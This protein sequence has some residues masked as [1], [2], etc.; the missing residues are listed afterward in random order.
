M[1]KILIIILFL[2]QISSSAWAQ[3]S[4]DQIKKVIDDFFVAMESKDTVALDSI[5]HTDCMLFSSLVQKGEPMIEALRKPSFLG[6]MGR[7]IKKKYVYDERLWT[8]NIST[9]DN[10]ATVWTEYTLFSGKELKVS[11]CGVNVFTLAKNGKDKW[12]IINITDTRRADNCIEE[13]SISQNQDLV[14]KLMDN[15][16]QAAA[17]ADEDKFFGAM[18]EDGIYLGT[19]AT[20]RWL[21]D[22]L[23]TWAKSA[24]DRDTAWA[25]TPSKR[26]IYF[27]EN[28]RVAWFE[29]MLDTWM[30]T[31]RGSGVV[32]KVGKEWKIKHYNL[33]IMVPNDLVKDFISLVKIGPSKEK[34]KPK[35]KK[36]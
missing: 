8:Y 23:K 30:G 29:E 34:K 31:C 33:S 20:E 1:K 7:A 13:S 32:V 9:E 15:W 19:D 16:H 28:Q 6:Y 26:Q 35:Q 21:R 27:G 14:N 12:L 5:M 4:N 3:N 2:Q 17:V 24:F 22:E 11:H 36:Q 25:F 10:M 18:T